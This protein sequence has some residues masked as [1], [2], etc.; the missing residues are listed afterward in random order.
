MFRPLFPPLFRPTER[1]QALRR[2]RFRRCSP[3]SPLYLQKIRKGARGRLRRGVA[4]ARALAKTGGTGGTPEHWQVSPAALSAFVFP[5]G[6]TQGGTPNVARTRAPTAPA[7]CRR[8]DPG[9]NLRLIDRF[10]L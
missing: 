10:L 4:G 5:P 3:C 7:L 8:V 9:W 6:G 1:A 2:R